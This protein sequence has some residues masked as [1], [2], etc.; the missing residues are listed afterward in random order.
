MPF[1]GWYA[2]MTRH[3]PVWNQ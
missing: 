2:E 1:G 3:V